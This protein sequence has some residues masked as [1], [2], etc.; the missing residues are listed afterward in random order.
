VRII[1]YATLEKPIG[2]PDSYAMARRES[3]DHDDITPSSTSRLWRVNLAFKQAGPAG[4]CSTGILP[5]GSS[6]T[7]WKPL[8][9]RAKEFVVDRIAQGRDGRRP[10][11]K[12]PP[13]AIYRHFG[14]AKLLR[15][16][17]PLHSLLAL[18]GKL[19]SLT[20]VIAY[21]PMP[22]LGRRCYG[23]E[24][25][26]VDRDRLRRAHHIAAVPERITQR[27]VRLEPHHDLCPLGLAK[28]MI[29][30]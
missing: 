15:S 21:G 18:E 8:P 19:A 27:D 9:L 2:E 16:F 11:Q 20:L 14:A 4:L 1:V 29:G 24:L 25:N 23:D 26:H 10:S 30:L 3:A 7:G 17:Q 5:V 13:T 6:D 12:L 22:L 28:R